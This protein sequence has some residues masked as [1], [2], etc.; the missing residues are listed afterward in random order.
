VTAQRQTHN[1]R[2]QEVLADVEKHFPGFAGHPITWSKVPDGQDPPDF[3]AQAPSGR[4]GL[5]FIEWLDGSQMGAAKGRESQRANIVRVIADNWIEHQPRNVGLAVLIPAWGLRIAPSDES[6]L[7]LE[8]Y[9]CVE[10]IDSVWSS[11]PARIGSTY[12]QA[13]L[14]GYPTLARYFEGIRYIGGEQHGFCW[15]DVEQDKG[16]YDPSTT[17]QTLEQALDKKLTL[18]ST[19]EK[20]AELNTLGLTE[21]NLLVHGGINAY[22]YNTPAHPLSLEQIAWRGAEFYARH[23]QRHIFD[24]VWFFDSLNSA[25]SLNALIGLPPGYGD[26]KWLAGLWPTFEVYRLGGHQ[27]ES[28]E[29][30]Q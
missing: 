7:K 19:P 25:D 3:V 28:N 5:E 1:Q 23:P 16:N 27:R 2:E 29:D 15:I 8:F 22:R 24:R 13:D 6:V 9:R 20:H 17:I 10:A 11:N 12:Y 18:Y 26:V 4:I 14:S 30:H 21:L